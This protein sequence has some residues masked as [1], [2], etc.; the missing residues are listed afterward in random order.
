MTDD[1]EIRATIT[2]GYPAINAVRIYEQSWSAK[3]AIDHS[4]VPYQIVVKTL[5]D[6]CIVCESATTPGSL[7][8]VNTMDTNSHG[9]ALRVPIKPYAD[10]TAT[11]KS[12]YYSSAK[13]HG[14]EI[15]KR[16]DA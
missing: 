9:H 10:G 4:D 5:Q 8:F 14:T 15:W 3:V 13:S 2:P 12:A 6:P 16:G 7:V 11:F 1:K